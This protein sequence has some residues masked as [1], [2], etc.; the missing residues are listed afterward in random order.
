MLV[1]VRAV[2]KCRSTHI[3][4]YQST[5]RESYEHDETSLTIIPN[6]SSGAP[7]LLGKDVKLV[8]VRYFDEMYLVFPLVV[9]CDHRLHDTSP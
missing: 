9:L 8:F 7:L 5:E 4:N 1:Q 3:S 2:P 6:V